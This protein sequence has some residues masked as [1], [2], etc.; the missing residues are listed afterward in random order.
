MNDLPDDTTPPTSQDP[1]LTPPASATG[2]QD[3]SLP[4]A[5]PDRYS[6][7][8]EPRTD[9]SRPEFAADRPVWPA[10]PERP[11]PV[12]HEPVPV[13]PVAPKTTGPRRGGGVAGPI[14]AASLLSA[15][16]ASGGTYLAVSASGALDRPT[17]VAPSSPAVDP[18]SGR[19]PVTIDESSATIN[20]AAKVGP[21]VVR[22]ATEAGRTATDP[23]PE[24]GVGSGVIYD[25]NGWILTNRHVVAGSDTLTVELQDG[26]QLVGSIYGIDTLTDLAI[27]KVDATGLPTAALGDSDALKVGQLTIAIGSPL[28][29]YSNSVTSGILS[30]KGRT[31]D[32]QGGRL[33]NLLQTDTA[34]NPGNSG[35]PLLDASGAVIGI[36]TAIAS[37]A[38]G[39]G[40]AIPI[41][42]AKPIMGQAVAGEALTR[43]YIGVRFE[44]I[45]VQVAERESLSVQDGALVNDGQ[46]PDGSTLP[47]IVPGGPADRAGLES[48]DIITAIDGIT[49]DGEH[50]LDAVISQFSPG[51]VVPLSVFRDGTSQTIDI[52]L[53]TRPA[54]L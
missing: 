32:V 10:Q 4:T 22:I 37:S 43:P 36:N 38:E 11:A 31:I 48:G 27:V 52:T 45:N 40:F 9:W 13:A 16:L 24:T 5:P 50:P 53:G 14:L 20:V 23:I 29:T 28:G 3:A 17:T 6:P 44:T 51:Q 2:P 41:D 1:A 54:D 33:T 39:I 21:A 7:A 25:S 8:P 47:A 12:W 18:A 42:L 30:A 35:G 34:I 46:S 15:V 19:Q 49:L 26:R